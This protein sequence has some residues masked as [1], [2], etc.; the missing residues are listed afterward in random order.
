LKSVDSDNFDRICKIFSDIR[1][2]TIIV[3]TH[4]INMVQYNKRFLMSLN[5]KEETQICAI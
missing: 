3:S 2:N 1:V 4:D 5:D